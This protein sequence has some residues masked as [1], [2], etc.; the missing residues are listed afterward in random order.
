MKPDAGQ[1]AAAYRACRTYRDRG[2]AILE[3]SGTRS[4]AHFST[5]AMQP[6]RFRYD[7]EDS[8][9]GRLVVGCN[10]HGVQWW[11][12]ADPKPQQA[13]DLTT[14]VLDMAEQHPEL[15]LTAA[16]QVLSIVPPLLLA[17]LSTP[18]LGRI[19]LIKD[20]RVGGSSVGGGRFGV[21][22]TGVQHVDA[23]HGVSE[24]SKWIDDW[25]GTSRPAPL[26]AGG[27]TITATMLSV[28]L[29]VDASDYLIRRFVA[30]GLTVDYWPEADSEID[31][32]EFRIS[33]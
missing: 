17:A 2:D 13:R 30:G 20:W 16:F 32:A 9:F 26:P 25:V 19:G 3:L 21:E 18:P 6:A 8:S 15:Y 28:S 23:V 1:L 11:T 4:S 10:D 12:S 24:M 31:E 7:A 33:G 22:V 5:R 27:A 14:A 29:A